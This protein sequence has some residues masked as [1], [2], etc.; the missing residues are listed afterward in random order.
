[1]MRFAD[2][3]EAGR[4]LGERLAGYAG[5]PGLLVLALPRGGVPVAAQVAAAL[6]SPLDVFVVRK[7]GVPGQEELAMGAI[8]SG[9]V[10]V[11]NAEVVGELGLSDEVI[12]TVAARERRELER[13]LAVYRGD[14]PALDVIGRTIILV[15]DGI[16]TGS[17]MRAALSALRR[18]GPERIV[19]AVPV[20]PPTVEEELAGIADEVICLATPM[21]FSAVGLWYEDFTP[22]TDDEVRRILSQ[23]ERQGAGLGWI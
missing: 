18:M 7:L 16:A 8:A 20:A 13:R 5:R 15:D 3:A 1:M 4:L 22:T 17:T 9:G 21:P 14:R 2:R 23:G 12:E 6:R 10:R 19:A 11:L